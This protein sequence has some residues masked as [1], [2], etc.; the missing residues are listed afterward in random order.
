MVET[1]FFY[2]LFFQYLSL[3]SSIRFLSICPISWISTGCWSL[4]YVPSFHFCG[5]V[6]VYPTAEPCVGSVL[7]IVEKYWRRKNFSLSNL[8]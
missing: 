8:I 4:V 5:V 1:L 6:E 3:Y 7:V 2:F